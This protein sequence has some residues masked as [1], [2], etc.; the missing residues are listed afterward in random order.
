MLLLMSVDFCFILF[1]S[2]SESSRHSHALNSNGNC[3]YCQMLQRELR[4]SAIFYDKETIF[5]PVVLFASLIIVSTSPSW[6]FNWSISCS[7]LVWTSFRFFSYTEGEQ[8]LGVGS[9]VERRPSEYTASKESNK[10]FFIF[11]S[12]LIN[13]LLKLF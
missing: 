1:V 8:Y 9:V 3:R 4:Y 6:L 5:T 11:E 10:I 12:N 2:S 7:N 13:I